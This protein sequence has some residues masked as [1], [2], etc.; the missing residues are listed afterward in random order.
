MQIWPSIITIFVWI[1]IFFTVNNFHTRISS[2]LWLLAFLIYIIPALYL[3]TISD[4]GLFETVGIKLLERV[5]FYVFDGENHGTFPFLPFMNWF[6]AL[7]HVLGKVTTLSF[8]FFVRLLMITAVFTT[9]IMIGKLNKSQDSKKDQLFFLFNPVNLLVVSFHGQA[10]I[11]LIFFVLASIF[12]LKQKHKSIVKSAVLMGLSILTKTWSVIFIPLFFIKIKE[13]SKKCLWLLTQAVIIFLITG[14]YVRLFHS[15]F[16]LLV[17]TLTSHVGGAPGFWGYTGFMSLVSELI[18]SVSWLINSLED[19]ARYILIFAFL[20]A[21]ALIVKKR[22]P[23]LPSIVILLLTFKLATPGWGIQYT[24]WILPFAAVSGMTKSLKTYSYLAIP[25][26][27]F[28]YL[29]II[30]NHSNSEFLSIVS[31]AIGLP[32]WVYVIYWIVQLL[33][34]YYR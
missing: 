1:I 17:E 34:K 25:Y 18:P 2:K 31:I 32:V 22:I 24:A 5:D 26:V 20:V 4:V 9:T 29:L 21:F 6:Y 27:A 19:K 33:K 3:P 23:L 10:D 28:S 16:A 11:L 30:T 8:I 12:F 13:F 15:D 7:A 14:F